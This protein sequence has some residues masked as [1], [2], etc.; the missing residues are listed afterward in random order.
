[1][2]LIKSN[3]GGLGGS[4]SP[5]GAL[6]SFYSH[7][8]DQSLRFDDGSSHHLTFTPSS[9]GNQ[10]TW[11]WS[12]WIK[13][14][15]LG[16][17]QN[18]FNPYRGGDGSN[19]SQMDFTTNDQFQI[20]DS[21]ATR[22]NKVTTRR[23]R[24][25]SAWY[26]IVVALDID[27]A[28]AADRVKIYVN[29]DRETSFSTNS[30]PGSSNWGWNAAHEHSLGS[31]NHSTDSSFFDGYM[32]EVHF[33]DGTALDPTSFG[34]TKDGVWI[35]KDYS[36][37]YGSNGW[38][39]PF[40]QDEASG[41]SA[42]FDEGDN[43]YV[44][45]TDPGTEYVIGSS[46]DYTLELFFN[47]TPA[48]MGGS[49][50]IA[51]YYKT[52]SPSGYFAAQLNLSGNVIN[53][54]HG[55]GASYSFSFTGGDVVAGQWH[56]LAFNRSSGNLRCFL[57]GA[58]K[59]STQPSNTKTHDIPEFRVNKAHATSNVT[60][61]GYVSNVRLVIG[62]AVYADGS[63]I[64]VPTSTLTAVTNTKILAC[65]TTT[66]TADASSNNVTGTASGNIFGSNVSPFADYN[67]YDDR[68]GN[69]NDWAP[70]N[71]DPSDLM[72]DSPTNNF[73]TLNPLAE[74]AVNIKTAAVLSE[75]NL[76][77][78]TGGFGSGTPWGGGQSTIAIPTDKKIYCEMLCSNA[79][80]ASWF[81]AVSIPQLS[82]NSTGSSN[83][84]QIAAYN[85]SVMVNGTETDYGS[86][87]GLGGLGVASLAS[88]DILQIAVDGATGKVWF[89]RNGTYFK[90]PSTDNSGTTGDPA[91]GTNEIGTVTN[92]DGEPLFIVVGGGSSTV[93]VNF[94]ADS[95]FAGEKTSGSAN[96]TDGEGI[97]DFYYTPP[98]GY[99]ALCASNISD[100]T[101]GPG[102]STQSDDY[103]NLVVYTGDNTQGVTGVGFQPDFVWAK[104]RDHT[105][106]HQLHDSVRGA[107]AGA[108]FSNSTSAETAFQFD[109]FDSDGFTT[110][111]GNITGINATGDSQ[112]A[113]SWKA[114][115][116]SNTFNIN[117]TGY[118]TASDASLSGGDIT[119]T[120]ASI[121]TTSGISIIAYTGNGSANQTIKH[122]LSSDPEFTIIKCRD[123]NSNNNQWQLSSSHIGDDYIYFTATGSTG[124][125]GV[126]PTSGDATTVTIGR[127]GNVA[128]NTNDNTKDFIMYNF[129]SV[130][131]YCK[132][133]SYTGNSS[134]DGTFV[135]C[136]FRP[137]YVL[138]RRTSSTG[139]WHIFDRLRENPFNV[140]D[141][142]IEADNTDAENTTTNLDIDL[143]SNGFKLRGSFDNINAGTCFFIAF[144]EAPFKFANAR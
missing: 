64:T 125:A 100:S 6:G 93:H 109:S 75:G 61:D 71:H 135:H 4:G 121:N 39:L 91:A 31:Y 136:N 28:T 108:L 106:N 107:T 80:G 48:E 25:P 43:S 21:G 26:H 84:G 98:T 58:Q 126:F 69:N 40:S 86:S 17:K 67:F 5:G 102:A 119:P 101:I 7:T 139:G 13:R 38:H 115:G 9:A 15:T 81:G 143:V 103:F 20:Y 57:D 66:V 95:S 72:P 36:G 76:V 97:G 63:S 27:N 55:N 131:G 50:Y 53:F 34:E 11:T 19:E 112:V 35:P 99:V 94:G 116:N 123:T 8:L 59:G 12:A 2:S 105:Y 132:V 24:D 22:G 73:A 89:G 104:T 124:T 79:A 62:S 3:G 23:F 32:T 30:N 47:P 14:G 134:A 82:A 54:Y 113:W 45:W 37:S 122:G 49:S 10:K 60:F 144:A 33:I 42:F 120:G 56:H 88:G 85:R 128:A 110:D 142:R 129:H 18:I 77:T 78:A 83:T 52:T 92:T 90:S 118:A 114:G 74:D 65:T 96:A 138:C 41:A 141:Q 117:G 140:I 137:A 68:S 44:A 16:T 29:G 127:T 133:G 87:A 70:N 130:D 51:G 1:M 111:S 46:D